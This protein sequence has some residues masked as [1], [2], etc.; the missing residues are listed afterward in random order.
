MAATLNA[1]GSNVDW[2]FSANGWLGVVLVF[3]LARVFE[4]G[5]RMRQ[6]LESMI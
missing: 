1:A 3:V 6:D 4:E 2:E 5:T